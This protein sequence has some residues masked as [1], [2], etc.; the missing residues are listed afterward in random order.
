MSRALCGAKMWRHDVSGIPG[1]LGNSSLESPTTHCYPSQP[2]LIP[3]A[4]WKSPQTRW[5]NTS[6]LPKKRRQP[7]CGFPTSTSIFYLSK[8]FLLCQINWLTCQKL[9][10]GSEY[11]IHVKNAFPLAIG[12]PCDFRRSSFNDST[13]YNLFN[14]GCSYAF[15]PRNH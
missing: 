11:W 3:T 14:L 7:L 4:V 9:Q 2:Q 10:R 5:P 1:T 13:R 15:Q 12:H 6:N 8:Q